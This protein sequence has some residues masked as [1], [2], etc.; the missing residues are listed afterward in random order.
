MVEAGTDGTPDEEEPPGASAAVWMLRGMAR[1]VSIPAF[2]LMSATAGF[3]A[4]AR[5]TGF[6]LGEAV[7]ISVAVFA[8][9][10]Q[11]LYV[12]L[13]GAGAALPAVMLAVGLS[14]V[15]FLPMTMAWAPVVRGPRT[16]KASLLFLSW[17]V[18]ITAWVFAMAELPKLPRAAR[19][20]F[21]AGFAGSLVVANALVVVLAWQL[22]DAFPP[23]VAAALLLLTPIY[24][25]LALWG[26]ARAA[27]DRLA[28][29]AGI[30]LG[31]V[32]TVLVP[33]LDLLLAGL[34]G[35]SGAYLATRLS[36][37]R[38]VRLPWRGRGGGDG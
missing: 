23:A 24:F 28:L 33:E 30:V 1:I 26:A 14:S 20:P 12:G 18:A 2:V 7:V 36:R 5:E 17:F 25:M 37:G 15:R 4:L 29:A 27:V 11:V 22:L 35:G 6:S 19:A 34:L 3:A 9:P 13:A 31:P 32:F 10:G 21:F 8:L 38:G 16:G